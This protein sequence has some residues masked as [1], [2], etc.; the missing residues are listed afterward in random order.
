[1]FVDLSALDHNARV[2][3]DAARA[4]GMAVRPALKTFQSP[5]LSAYVLAGLPEPRGLIFDLNQIDATLAVAPAGTDLMLGWAPTLGELRTYLARP[6]PAGTPAHRLRFLVDS[7]ALLRELVALV[8]VT[9]RPLPLEV[10]LQFDSGTGA[11][12]SR[13]TPRSSRRV[14]CCAP[15][16]HG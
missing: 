9:P 7:L 16:A 4:L 13:A 10:A 2:I 3:G 6:E 5:Q 11:A 1:M 14:T 12:G 15:S 8:R